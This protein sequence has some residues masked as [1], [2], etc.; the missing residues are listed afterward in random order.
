MTAIAR[1]PRRLALGTWARPRWTEFGLLALASAIALVAYLP[2]A[3]DPPGNLRTAALGRPLA[4]IAIIFFVH[5]GLVLRGRG[6]DQTL[7]PLCLCLLGLGLAFTNRLAPALANRQSAWIALGALVLLA[8]T[9]APDYAIQRLQR[10]RYSWAALGIALVGLTFVAGRSAAPGGPRLWLGTAR[11]G[12]Q[13]AE[14]LKLLLVLFLAGYLAERGE[15][16]RQT[17][18]RCGRLK[19]PPLPYI[20]PLA[21][22]LGLALGLL[23]A[24]RDLGAA[25]LL[26]AIA[27]GMIY[28]ASGRAAY[29]TIALA[30]F[31]AAAY[32]IRQHVEVVASRFH[33][34]HD[35]WSDAQGAGY[36]LVQAAMAMAAGGILGTGLGLGSPTDIPAVHTDFVYAA[37]VEELG[38]GGSAAL[39]AVYCLLTLR[40]LRVAAWAEHA[41]ERWLAVGLSLSLAFQVFVIVGGIVRLI[42]LTGL[43]LPFLAHGGTSLVVCCCTVGLLLRLSGSRA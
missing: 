31:L 38:L 5:L 9:Q 18:T 32:L 22:M 28:A 42:P 7:L 36:Q 37:V 41:F 43:T 13:P 20:A 2:L 27:L 29:V 17:W 4:L 39:L 1:S 10:Y 6:E 8:V 21:V 25:L 3:L 12:F 33:I 35:P 14:G 15:L 23:V 11:F 26:F 16:L 24:Q 30:M 34:W 40:G 19:L